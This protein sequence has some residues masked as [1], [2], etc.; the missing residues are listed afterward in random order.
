M[1]TASIRK[2]NVNLY[3]PE[4]D[5]QMFKQLLNIW[6]D[7]NDY[8]ELPYRFSRSKLAFNI[9][10]LI[11]QGKASVQDLKVFSKKLQLAVGALLGDF[12]I[13]EEVTGLK[14]EGKDEE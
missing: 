7:F 14:Y 6:F 11:R 12:S 3:Y 4:S 1:I 13:M 2:D 9:A 5:W 8:R 10:G